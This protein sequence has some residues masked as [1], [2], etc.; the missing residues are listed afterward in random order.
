MS[1]NADAALLLE[2]IRQ[3]D[4]HPVPRRIN[5]RVH[6]EAQVLS[7]ITPAA[8]LIPFCLSVPGRGAE[9]EAVGFLPPKVLN[10]M[11]AYNTTLEQ[12]LW[13][14]LRDSSDEPPWGVAFSHD[15]TPEERT[16]ELAKMIDYWKIHQTFPE[17][18]NSGSLSE[19][20]VKSISLFFA[21]SWK[22][23]VYPVWPIT[24]ERLEPAFYVNQ[25][26]ARLFGV[27]SEGVFMHGELSKSTT[28]VLRPF[29]TVQASHA[30]QSLENT[31]FGL[32]NGP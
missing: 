28:P 25:V 9:Q 30:I 13:A 5:P 17:V 10:A 27:A 2:G 31:D 4:N 26:A 8:V 16:A 32:L 19:L 24:S 18:L 29:F 15:M 3:C 23:E 20:W 11:L 7:D 6:L 1:Q 14:S 12:P 22:D 21:E